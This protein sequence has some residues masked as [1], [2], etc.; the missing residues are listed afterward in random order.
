MGFG[1]IPFF[2]FTAQFL[3]SKIAQESYFVFTIN[4][5]LWSRG[6]LPQGESGVAHCPTA[7]DNNSSIAVEELIF[8]GQT[9]I[10]ELQATDALESV[11][12]QKSAE[13]KQESAESKQET[14]EFGNCTLTCRHSLSHIISPLLTIVVVFFL[15]RY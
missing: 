10:A 14:A 7:L 15:C 8:R 6:I 1:L 4:S 13:S 9:M 11:H 3:D 12:K 2:R 5:I